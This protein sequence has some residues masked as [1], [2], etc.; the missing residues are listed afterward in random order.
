MRIAIPGWKTLEIAAAVFD[1][2]G[3]LAVDGVL[4]PG[5]AVGLQRLGQALPVYVLT[6]D[7]FGC[8][9]TF[10]ADL[11]LVFQRLRS[12]DHVQEKANFVRNLGLAGVAAIGNGANDRLMLT[13]AALAIAVV[14]PEGCFRES[15][16]AADIVVPSAAD[17]IA[18]LLSP[19]R[20]IATL[21][22]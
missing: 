1:Y 15:L 7:T 19:Q 20:L 14:G 5:V 2:N 13:A 12:G 8:A 11:P 17:A 9:E 16:L 6:A 18:L 22:R 21:R 3:T 4:R 10:L